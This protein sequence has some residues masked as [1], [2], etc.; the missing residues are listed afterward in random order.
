[1]A[2]ELLFSPSSLIISTCPPLPLLSPWLSIPDK[3]T[4]TRNLESG[5][6]QVLMSRS[7]GPCWPAPSPVPHGS[8]RWRPARL[9]G[10]FGCSGSV[11]LGY[12]FYVQL[13]LAHVEA[14]G[15]SPEQAGGQHRPH[16]RGRTPH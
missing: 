15:T 11:I 16:A 1:M 4:T 7:S 5:K 12:Q 3:V 14:D 13:Q 2:T 6:G 8:L 10:P 9:I